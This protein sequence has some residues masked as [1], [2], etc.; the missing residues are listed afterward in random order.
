ML[1]PTA[2]G[3]NWQ[4]NR[5]R[6]NKVLEDAKSWLDPSVQR[7]ELAA[8]EAARACKEAGIAIPEPRA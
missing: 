2:L 8:S 7:F 5:A 3:M 6:V 4:D 1:T